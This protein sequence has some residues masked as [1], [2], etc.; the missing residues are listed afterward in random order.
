MRRVKGELM[1]GGGVD[2]VRGKGEG[3]ADLTG[4]LDG[5]LSLAVIFSFN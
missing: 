1:A 5:Q 3:L 2:G 4:C